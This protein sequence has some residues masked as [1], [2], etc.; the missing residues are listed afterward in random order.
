M[1]LNVP[2]N[3]MQ[4]LIYLPKT[5]QNRLSGVIDKKQL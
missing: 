1:A 2:K 4:K 5:E 3:I